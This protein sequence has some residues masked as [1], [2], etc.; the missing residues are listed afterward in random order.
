MKRHD[1]REQAMALIFEKSFRDDDNI[2][3]IITDAFEGRNEQIDD[4]A[5]NLSLGVEAKMEDID[6]KITINLTGWKIDRL[7]RVA[8]AIMRVA[9]CEIDSFDDI[10]VSV[11]INEAVELAK[12]FATDEDAAYINGV[13]GAYARSQLPEKS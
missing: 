10:P 1:A 8:L 2:L 11:S 13:L 6:R 7:S 4:F 9:I 3:Q 5:K 12:K